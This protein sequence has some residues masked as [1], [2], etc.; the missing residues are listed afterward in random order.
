MGRSEPKTVGI[1][2]RESITVLNAS[3]TEPVYDRPP[4]SPYIPSSDSDSDSHASD[5][6]GIAPSTSEIAQN[7]RELSAELRT[8]DQKQAIANSQSHFQV[9]YHNRF[10]ASQH[11][12]PPL[13]AESP[14]NVPSR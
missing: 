13:I 9:P 1:G 6:I 3:S 12:G 11:D 5:I 7:Y 8:M 2:N 10:L 14:E 4:S